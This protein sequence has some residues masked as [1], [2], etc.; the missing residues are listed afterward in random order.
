VSEYFLSYSHRLSDATSIQL[1]DQQL[2]TLDL[3][4]R[5]PP[6]SPSKSLRLLSKMFMVSLLA[7]TPHY[8]HGLQEW[9]SPACRHAR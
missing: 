7:H 3:D 1:C 8:L 5:P 9:R 6:N 2:D 4:Y